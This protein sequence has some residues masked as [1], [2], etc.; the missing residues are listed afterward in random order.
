LQQKL[1]K[2]QMQDKNEID[3]CIVAYELN[4]NTTLGY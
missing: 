4:A 1:I 2:K 3:Y